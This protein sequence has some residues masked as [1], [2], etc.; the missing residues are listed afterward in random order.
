MRGQGL[1]PER[2][3][4]C[5]TDERDQAASHLS[6]AVT[7]CSFELNG[8][9][10]PLIRRKCERN[11]ERWI[12]DDASHFDLLGK[13]LRTSANADE[14]IVID[15][16]GN[17]GFYTAFA[18]KLGFRV[19]YYEPQP[20][21]RVRACMAMLAN[22]ATHLVSMFASGVGR[23]RTSAKIMASEGIAFAG[24]PCDA[25]D[26][27]ERCMQVYA[28]DAIYA[29]TSA[30]KHVPIALLKLDNE[31]WELPVLQGGMRM[32]EQKT[33]LTSLPGRKR[34]RVGSIFVEMV[35]GRWEERSGVTVSAGAAIFAHLVELGYTAHVVSKG[36]GDPQYVMCP[37]S[38]V[39]ALAASSGACAGQPA[40]T[41]VARADE[42]GPLLDRMVALDKNMP[43]GQWSCCNFFFAHESWQAP[44][45]APKPSKGG[46]GSGRT[47]ALWQASEK[48]AKRPKPPPKPPKKGINSKS[49]KEH[50]A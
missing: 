1:K 38:L 23:L 10:K 19:H 50:G 5:S 6:L 41:T 32:L 30:T 17:H 43:A 35:P 48:P 40:C 9:E 14:A 20:A 18:A 13:F 2:P 37:H 24:G 7:A 4:F 21:L 11:L 25:D 42:I 15:V 3:P 46:S 16:G 31:G 8:L 49:D 39:D 12:G 26:T 45:M 28:L 34:A 22:N 44:D 47:P 27:S 36:E 33:A 29:M